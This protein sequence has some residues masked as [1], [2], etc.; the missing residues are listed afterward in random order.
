MDNFPFF[1]LAILL[2][3]SESNSKPLYALFKN[4]NLFLYEIFTTR[5]KELSESEKLLKLNSKTH[6]I[7]STHKKE[8]QYIQKGFNANE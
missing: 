6:I 4:F 5:L 2:V 3:H 7:E 8:V 1:S